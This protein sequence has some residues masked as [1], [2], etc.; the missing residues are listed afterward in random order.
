MLPLLLGIA[1]VC[2]AIEHLFRGWRLPRVRSWHLR[3]VVINLVQV[4]VVVLA[5]FTWERWLSAYSLFHLS[6]SGG[7]CSLAPTTTR[8]RGTPPVASMMPV[9]ND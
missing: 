2:F 9:S 6:Q 8:P 4:G 7:T 3:V 5:G 1:V